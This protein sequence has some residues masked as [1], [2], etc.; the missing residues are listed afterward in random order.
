MEYLMST[1]DVQVVAAGR[2]PKR[3]HK[4]LIVIGLVLAFSVGLNFMFD[5][6]YCVLG[7]CLSKRTAFHQ[8]QL[9]TRRID[10]EQLLNRAGVYCL[11]FQTGA[12]TFSDLWREYL[13]Q[14]DSHS[15]IVIRK[16]FGYR[17]HI[18]GVFELLRLARRHS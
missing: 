4:T 10:A 16:E 5:S 15:G 14:W 12:C 6:S 2:S 17:F 8:I 11:T 18:S 1:A 7:G 13:I 9:G 3:E